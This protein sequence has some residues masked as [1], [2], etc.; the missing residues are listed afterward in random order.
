MIFPK[1]KKK[2]NHIDKPHVLSKTG[3]L[4]VK[5][6]SWIIDFDDYVTFHNPEKK[7]TAE[8]NAIFIL[9]FMGPTA[10]SK[11][12]SRGKDIQ[13][14]TQIKLELNRW[15]ETNLTH[16]KLRFQEMKQD[17]GETVDEFV[18][19]LESIA[20]ICKFDNQKKKKFRNS[21]NNL[22][23]NYRDIFSECPGKTEIREHEIRTI[24]G[25]SPICIKPYPTL[26]HHKDIERNLIKEMI[27]NKII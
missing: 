11:I 16:E 1:K 13:S 24:P 2:M 10:R 25:S 7:W 14:V 17:M 5:I 9:N 15:E 19:K 4:V 27:R 18:Y 26:I 12:K 3:K 21:L 23:D 20:N 8:Q 6:S 22:M